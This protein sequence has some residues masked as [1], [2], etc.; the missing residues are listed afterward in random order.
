MKRYCTIC[1]KIHEGRCKPVFARDSR[2][3]RFRNTQAWRSKSAV[4]LD[5]DY[6]CC[7]V[8]YAAGNICTSGLSVHHITPLAVDYDRRLEEDNLITL[9][10]FHHEQAERG[11]IKAGFL[12]E[13]AGAEFL[14]G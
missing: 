1:H 8:C 13:L 12:R 6:H 9:C 2:A 3:D 7:R 11:A 10:R 4:I 14:P 5:R